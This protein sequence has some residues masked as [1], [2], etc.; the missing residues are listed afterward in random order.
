M[1]E[2]NTGFINFPNNRHVNAID[3]G[4][5][6]VY[7]IAFDPK[8]LTNTPYELSKNHLFMPGSFVA[9]DVMQRPPINSMEIT[10]DD[11]IDNQVDNDRYD[12]VYFP[13]FKKEGLEKLM[14][15]PMVSC[16]CIGWSEQT[17]ELTD[18]IGFWFASF[19]DLTHEGKKLY[20]CLKKLHNTKEV[21][22]LTFNNI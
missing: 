8:D 22:M 1:I 20:Y 13:H 14:S 11:L 9:D 12:S 7:I 17:Y 21:R 16:V 18:N 15:I 6:F 2:D 5:T 4:K 3:S 19:R 10:I